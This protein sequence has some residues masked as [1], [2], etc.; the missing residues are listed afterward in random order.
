M[1][2]AQPPAHRH[3]RAIALA[4][5]GPTRVRG[6]LAGLEMIS[7]ST[8]EPLGNVETGAVASVTGR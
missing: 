5:C 1:D 7:Y 6:S 8:G 3:G 4:V 2:H